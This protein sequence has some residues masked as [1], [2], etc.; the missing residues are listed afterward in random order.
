M[1]I[2]EIIVLFVLAVIP[3]SAIVLM[4]VGYIK[5][6]KEYEEA[7]ERIRKAKPLTGTAKEVFIGTYLAR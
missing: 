5:D 2:K 4:V 6:K 3:I 1:E 7:V